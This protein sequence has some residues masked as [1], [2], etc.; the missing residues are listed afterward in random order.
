MNLN[1]QGKNALIGGSSKGLGKA[2]AIEL[3]KLGANV[4]LMAR[5]AEL[6]A[7]VVQELVQIHPEQKHDFL[8]V[9][10]NKREELHQRVVGLLSL[11]PMHILVNNTGGPGGGP[12][13]EAKPEQFLEAFQNHLLCNHL[14]AQLVIPKMK[15][16][17]FGRIV[18]IVSTSV[19]VPLDNLGV[20]NTTRGAVASW[21]K[22]LANEVAKAG[23]TVNN[24]LPGFTI[25]ERLM[26]VLS[27][28]AQKKG[29]SLEQE[30]NQARE[31]IPCGRFGTPEEIAAV[32]AFLCTPAASY[33]T[34]TSILVDGGRT[35]S[36]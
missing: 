28:S 29:V 7:E 5:S 30:M 15:E 23:I 12:I 16:A 8:V 2:V 1:L 4:T 18:N 9:D 13:L 14:L 24:V 33:V 3:A 22:T 31:T 6:L 21:A 20:S 19:R 27:V 17:E 10:F 11:K 36:I 25:T 34:G 32:T 26:E 35:R